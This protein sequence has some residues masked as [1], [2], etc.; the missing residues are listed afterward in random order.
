MDGHNIAEG[1]KATPKL[2]H[3]CARP[4]LAPQ[5]DQIL[6]IKTAQ[7]YQFISLKSE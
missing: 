1:A 4:F 6:P 3:N 2:K 7:D 5:I